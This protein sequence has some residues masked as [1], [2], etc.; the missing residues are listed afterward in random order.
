MRNFLL[1]FQKI[2]WVLNVSIFVLCGIGLLSIASSSYGLDDFS[3]F[4]KQAV[5]IGLGVLLMLLVSFIDYRVL[6]NDPYF[7]LSLWI[8]GI[9]ALVGLIVLGPEIRGVKAWYRI[10]GV[11]IDPVEFMKITLLIIGAKYFSKRNADMYRIRHIILSGLYF[12]IPSVL[13]ILQPNIGSA[14]VLVILWIAILFVSG[15][16]MRH[17]I[18]LCLAGVVVLFAGWNLILHDYQKERIVSFLQPELDPLGIGWSQQQAR[19]SLGNGGLFGQ[20]F[21]NGT[22]TQ[23][24][25]LSEPQNDFV[26]S[27]IGEEF[28]LTGVTLLVILFV[29]MIYRVFNIGFKAETN[30]QRILATGFG[31]VLAYQFIVNVGMNVGFLPIIGLS[32]PFVSYGGSSML[33]LFFGVGILQSMRIAK[34]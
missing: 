10:A 28:G 20:G 23:Y 17:F 33:A 11:S 8:V 19:V 4:Y 29:I 6:R 34:S 26:F 22:Q 2:D 3:N 31:S 15:I 16:K 32:L 9:V 13:V 27:A 24:G 5:F 18:L 7:L 1:H 21:K 14:S 30:F 12:L 25:F